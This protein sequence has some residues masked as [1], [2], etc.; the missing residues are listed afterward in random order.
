MYDVDAESNGRK[1]AKSAKS[2]VSLNLT[3]W[4]LGAESQLAVQLIQLIQ[5]IQVSNKGSRK[6]LISASETFIQKWE[7]SWKSD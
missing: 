5:L 4:V 1:I 3:W 6:V 2:C 7:E